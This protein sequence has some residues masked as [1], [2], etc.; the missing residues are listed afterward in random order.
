MDCAII[1]LSDIHM[2]ETNNSIN[3]KLERLFEAIRNEIVNV[4]SI[5]IIISGDV[6]YSGKES[7]YDK[8]MY[9]LDKL[10]SNILSYT[11]CECNIVIVPGNH[12]CFHDIAKMKVREIVITSIN[13]TNDISDEII[14]ECCKVQSNFFDFHQMYKC[15]EEKYS[16]NLI[17]IIEFKVKN[18][19]IIFNCYNTAW[20]S[21]IHEQASKL[22]FPIQRY[23]KS[24]F[25]SK[26]DLT[27]SIMHHP[28]NWENPDNKRLFSRHIESTSDITLI[29]HEHQSSC[30][31]I[32]D[33]CGNYTEFVE[34]A[35]LQDT[36]DTDNS[37]FNLIKYN[38]SNMTHNILRYKWNGT[39][40]NVIENT[41]CV[42]CK[43]S[44][45][46][47]K[48][49]FNITEDFEK[50]IN[51]V[52]ATFTHPYKSCLQ[53][54]DFFIFPDLRR[55]N[56]ISTD[57]PVEKVKFDRIS[58]E[59][60]INFSKEQSKLLITGDEK[61][62]K[63]ALARM[64]YKYYYNNDY[65]PILIDG[66]RIR[67]SSFVNVNKYIM[68][69]LESQYLNNISGEYNQ[70]SKTS[71]VLIIDNF[72]KC[73][74]NNKS[75]KAFFDEI[76]LYYSY[77]VVLGDSLLQIKTLHE[78]IFS[79]F[80]KYEII[81]F[82]H[83]LRNKLIEKWN[84]LG[85]NQF[86]ESSELLH[87]NQES[88]RVVNTI[89]GKNYVPSYPLFILT[90]LQTIEMGRSQDLK[91]SAYGYYY[92]FLITQSLSKI[93][94]KHDEIEAYYN[95]MTE[96]ANVLSNKDLHEIS[97]EEFFDF[98]KKFCNEDYKISSSFTDFINF[99]KLAA[100][101]VSVNILENINSTYKFKYKYVYYYSLSKYLADNITLP[102]IRED[103]NSMCSKLYLQENANTIMFLIHHSKDP[104]I[105]DEI[106]KISS[107]I[108][109]QISPLTLE[110][111]IE[112]INSLIDSIPQLVLENIDAKEYRE[113][114]LAIEDDYELRNK[115]IEEEP[116]YSEI[117]T[118]VEND[119]LEYINNLNL[120]FKYIEILGQILKNYWGTLKGDRRLYIAEQTYML[121]L[122]ALASFH[123]ELHNSVDELVQ[124]IV[125]KVKEENIE[126]AHEIEI[127]SKNILFHLYEEITYTFIKKISNVIGYE[128]LS[129]TFKELV[130]KD[131]TIAVNIIDIATKLDFYRGF[132]ETE[133][134][135]LKKRIDKNMLA[136]NILRKMVIDYLYMY[137]TSYD[138]KDRIC[139]LLNISQKAQNL[140][141]KLSTDKK[142]ISN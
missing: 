75:K 124:E 85:R 137:E 2:Q 67:D 19:N 82:G 77:I 55:I 28:F 101:L 132:P 121:G 25:E 21:Q 83:L 87:I 80:E 14:S 44:L 57:E 107:Q 95:F 76:S 60:L 79:E 15:G 140:I 123:G 128:K 78:N 69:N 54:E 45:L 104:Y 58:S 35:V 66:E 114:K 50:Y 94:A 81:E 106:I 74:L 41:G 34:G 100:N 108:F 65:I 63:T 139:S 116:A 5:F 119:E 112:S 117:A 142:Y 141:Q 125:D 12:D 52:G 6:A 42:P 71:K 91:E 105:I 46:S 72:H 97:K 13:N 135:N 43:R 134:R 127:T 27:V 122:R 53:L 120:A 36:D 110:N 98:H 109:S 29:G 96:L 37:G 7:E 131:N 18:Y 3:D 20:L 31:A 22:L 56:K 51:D 136:Y 17:K 90:I 89:I 30:S 129:E 10:K 111:D 61:S 62:G 39:I 93:K 1:H 32:S 70:L 126:N 59:K 113:K 16:D 23:D 118:S 24:L 130:S 48:T 64:L 102:E 49:I 8:A 26:A 33:F 73:K 115:E 88:S 103:I 84:T 47:N 133:I 38:F 11:N 68:K 92:Q 86:V 9:F 138:D 40:Y 4:N 99:E